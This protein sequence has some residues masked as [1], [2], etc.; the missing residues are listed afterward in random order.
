MSAVAAQR[1]A[2]I[3]A[4]RE[5]VPSDPRLS[6][7]WHM[8]SVPSPFSRWNY[9]PEYE[10]HLIR[11]GTGR[12]VVGDRI[13][14]FSAGQLTLV[15]SNL[16]HHWISDLEPGQVIEDRDVVFQFHPQWIRQCQ[17]VLPE[18]SDVEPLLKKSARGIE[19]TGESAHRGAEELQQI[20]RSDGAERLQHIFGLLGVLA[21]APG[22]EHHTLAKGW[23]PPLD[24]EYAADIIDRAFAYILDNLVGDVRLS[25]AA[26]VIGMS[27]S[28]FSKYFKRVSGQTFSDTVRQLR[29]AHACK[30]L[31][32]TDLPISSIYHRVGYANLSN[33]N[34]QFRA[35]YGATPRD[36]RRRSRS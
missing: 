17:A 11:F 15:G 7:R 30:L 14:V 8:H 23:L 26:D 18:L 31:K 35:H 1:L 24:D 20:G 13:D 22:S 2:S 34:R 6:A 36:F 16:P 3:P 21:A 19:F 9:H 28:A 25:T 33:F 10:V 5:V 27:E 32:E 29:L 12:Y 4:A